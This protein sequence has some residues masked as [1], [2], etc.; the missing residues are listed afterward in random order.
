[1]LAGVGTALCG[2]AV[3][4]HVWRVLEVPLPWGL[5]LALGAAFAVVYAAGLLADAPG[6][7]GVGAGW[8]IATMWLQSPRSEGDF[9]VVA[10]W[11]GYAFLFGGMAVVAAAVVLSSIAA[12]RPVRR[13]G[14]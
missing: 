13:E 6:F 14:R 3:H 7:L 5:L 10:D 11:I 9:L 4:R 8:V 1:M 12:G 2:L